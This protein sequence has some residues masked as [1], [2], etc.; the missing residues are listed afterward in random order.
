MSA[1][2]AGYEMATEVFLS[3][4]LFLDSNPL[5]FRRQISILHRL[6]VVVVY[7][8]VSIRQIRLICTPHTQTDWNLIQ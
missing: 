6:F 3:P 4:S 7:F 1:Y 5:R 8:S 2:D